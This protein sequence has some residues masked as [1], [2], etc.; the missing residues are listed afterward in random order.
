[1]CLGSEPGV[2]SGESV[3][4]VNFIKR[5]ISRK[6]AKHAINAIDKLNRKYIGS[7]R[8]LNGSSVKGSQSGVLR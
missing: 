5:K 6:G 3:G 1:M 7:S 4:A 2:C 8:D